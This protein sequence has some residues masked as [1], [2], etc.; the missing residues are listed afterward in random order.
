MIHETHLKELKL[1]VMCAIRSYS[2][3]NSMNQTDMAYLL[4][5][6]QPRM[7]HLFKGQTDKFKLDQLLAWAYDLGIKATIQINQ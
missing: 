7:S 4:Q 3:Q 5:T 1:Q 2:V 6:T